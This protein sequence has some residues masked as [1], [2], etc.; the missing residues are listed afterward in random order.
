[1]GGGARV[2]EIFFTKNPNLKIAGGGWERLEFFFGMG[3]GIGGW[4]FCGW[5]AGVSEFFATLNSNLNIFFAGWGGEWGGG[6]KVS[7]F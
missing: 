7:D 2:S 5:G 6:A 1:M 3:V 4:G